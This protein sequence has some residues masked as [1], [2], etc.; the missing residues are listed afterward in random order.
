MGGDFDHRD[1]PAARLRSKAEALFGG[2]PKRAPKPRFVGVEGCAAIQALE[3]WWRAAPAGGEFV[4]CEALE[5][6]RTHETWRRA[7]DLARNGFVRTH[8]RQR[9]GGGKQYFAVRTSKR[10]E[11]VLDPA[12][13]ALADP[14]T[15]AIY[16]A[17]KR[18]AN[19]GQACQ[20]D[21]DLARLVGFTH[22]QQV[23]WRFRRLIDAGLIKSE[24]VY[25]GGVPSRVVTI[26]ASRHAGSAGGK[27]TAMPRRWKAAQEAAERELRAADDRQ[28]ERLRR[29]GL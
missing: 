3:A 28:I 13:A 6:I 15:D 10:L 5:P 29:A 7:G 11:P 16:R 8:E 23:Q 18:A 17:L 14:Q 26:C 12:E 27:A 20:T 21:S 19:F 1:E 24:Q 4:Y 9:A 25:D 22:R 2:K